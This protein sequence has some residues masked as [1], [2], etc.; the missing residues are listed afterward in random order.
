VFHVVNHPSLKT[1]HEISYYFQTTITDHVGL[2]QTAYQFGV[3][4]STLRKILAGGPISRFILKKIG[5][6]LEGRGGPTVTSKKKSSIERLLKVYQ[7]YQ[8]KGT[9]QA[10]GDEI[11]TSRERVRQLLKSGT[12]MGLFEYMP[13]HRASWERNALTSKKKRESLTPEKDHGGL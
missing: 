9:L 12:E 13:F 1:S 6:T 7:L 11:G 2:L 3:T 10:V 8:Q 4:P 5:M